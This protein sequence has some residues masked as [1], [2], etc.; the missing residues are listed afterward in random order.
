M[1]N[2]SP[3][4][5][6]PCGDHAITIELD[7]RVDVEISRQ[8]I[9]LYQKISSMKLPGVLDIIPAYSSVTIVYDLQLLAKQF[10][11]ASVYETMRV[12]LQNAADDISDTVV[13]ETRLIRIPVC[14]DS[15]LAP[16]II[17]LAALHQLSV[18]EV[19]QLH[20][21]VIY[22]V[23]MIGFLPGFAYMGSVDKK[24]ITPRKENP[25]T[26]VPAGSVGIAGEQTGIYPFSSPGGWQLIGQTPVPMFAANQSQPCYLQPGDS[27]QFFPITVDEFFKT[28]QV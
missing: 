25:R 15:S 20:T 23:Y 3:H 24:I 7:N 18:E 21:A 6:Y 4:T 9:S 1:I 26:N 28:K 14:Y 12:I 8:V 2:T 27:V 10:T 22:R 5:I 17:S 13:T 11:A 16:D 19:I